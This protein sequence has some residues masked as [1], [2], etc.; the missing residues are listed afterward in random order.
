MEKTKQKMRKGLRRWFRPNGTGRRI[1]TLL[2]SLVMV[3]SL[4]VPMLPAME[5]QAGTATYTDLIPKSTDDATKL[6]AKVVKFNGYDWYIIAD[7]STAV[8]A[9]SVTLLAKECIGASEFDG[10]DSTYSTSTVKSYLDGLTTGSGSFAAVAGAIKSVDLTDPAVSGAKLYLLSYDEAD[11]LPANIRKCNKADGAEYNEWWL[12]SAGEYDDYAACVFGDDGNVHVGGFYVDRARGVRPALQL[13][14]ASVIFSSGSKTFTLK[15]PYSDLVGTTTTVKFNGK[16]WYLIEDNS[17]AGSITLLAKECFSASKFGDTNNSYSAAT[18]KSYLD[19]LT[20][21]SGSFAAVA[22]AIKSVDLSDVGVTGAKLYLLSVSEANA[23]SYS[24]RKCTKATGADINYWW[25]RTAGTFGDGT[26][27][28]ACVAGGENAVDNSGYNG[29][30]TVLGIR[31]ALQ[32]DLSA[33]DFDSETKEFTKAS[34]ATPTFG[35]TAG[36]YA[37]ALLVTIGTETTGATIY[38]TTDGTTPTTSSTKYTKALNITET[39]TVKAIAVKDGLEKSA[40]ASATYTIKPTFYT[41]YLDQVVKFNDMEWYLIGDHSESETSGTVTLLA[42]ECIG[43][44]KFDAAGASNVYAGSTVATYLDTY[45]EENFS[46]FA[47]TIINTTNGRLYLLSADEAEAI[48]NGDIRECSKAS[49]AEANSWWLR[50]VGLNDY[51]AAYVSCGSGSVYLD[52]GHVRNKLGVRPALQLNL[53]KVNFDAEEKTFSP[54]ATEQVKAPE[55]SPV[56][57]SYDSAQSVTISTETTGA[58][59]YYTTDGTAP[60]TSSTKYTGAI[61]VGETTTIKAIAMKA[62][63]ENSAVA[64]ATY[65]IKPTLTGA[66]SDWIPKSTD[67]AAAL[68]DKVVKFSIYNWYI[69]EDDSTAIDAGSV[70]LLAKD[71]LTTS[72]FTNRSDNVYGYSQVKRMLDD[73]ITSGTWGFYNQADAIKSVDLTIYEYGKTTVQETIDGAKLYLLSIEEAKDLPE[74][75]RKCS[76]ITGSAY[77]WWLRSPGNETYYASSVGCDNGEVYD[78][79]GT[80]YDFGVRPAL[81]LDLSKVKFSEETKRFLPLV[82]SPVISPSAGTYS[83]AQ[84]VTISTST[85]G[86]KIYYTTDGTTPSTESTK[87]TGAISISKTTTIK[88]IA[89]ADGMADSDIAS[90]KYTIS[91]AP[92]KLDVSGVTLDKTTL[93]LQEGKTATLT[94]TVTPTDA[95]DKTVTWKSS[96]TTVATVDGSGKVTAEK[97][98]TATITVTATNGTDDTSD[99]QTATCKVTVKEEEVPKTDVSGVTLDNTTLTLQEGK[100]GSLKATVAPTDATDKTVTW[101]SSDT[102]VATVD[103]SGKVTAVKAGTATITVTA[104]NGTDDTSDDKTATCKVTVKEEEVPKVDVSGVTLDNTTLTLQEGKT[105]SLKATV[106]PTDATDKTVTWKSSDTSIATV[107]DSGKVMAVK[108]GTATITVTATNGTDDTSDDQTATCKVTVKE[109]EVPKVDVTGVTLDNTTLTLQ[110]G[111]TGSLKATVAPADATD[112][113]VTWKSS[114]TGVATVDDSGKVTAVKAGTT[115]I[116][117]T[118]TNGTADTADDKTATCTVT[119]SEEPVERVDVIGVTLDQTTLSLTEGESGTLKATVAP[120]DA[121]DATVVWTTGDATVATVDGSGKVTAVKVGTT[122]ITATATN[123]TEDT[124]DDKTATCEV[125]VSEAEAPKVD[126]TGV[127]LDKTTLSIEA[128]KTETLTATVEPEDAADKMVFWSSSDADV[129]TVDADGKITAVKAGTA[130]I[131]VTATNGTEDMEDDKEASCEVTVTDPASEKTGDTLEKQEDGSIRYMKDGSWQSAYTGLVCIDGIWYY[132]ENGVWVSDKY[133]FVEYEGYLFLVANGVLA[134]VNGLQM[135]PNG[136]NWYFCAEG[137]VVKHTGL[138]EYDDEWFYVENGVLDTGLNAL[139]EYD[140]GLFYVAAGRIVR[141]KSG[142]AQDPNSSDWYF[143]ALGE[144]QVKYTG[145]AFYDDEWFYVVNGKLAEDYTGPVEYDGESFNVV[146]GMVK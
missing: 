93:S 120:A 28:A 47:E 77:E 67:N 101:K 9:G 129:V 128:G 79:V 74:N 138:V 33:V 106:A 130:T 86:A 141:D 87:Y 145:L 91:D 109:E 133:G 24:I 75:V 15:T 45:Y 65:T 123:G 7:N 72:K 134:Q 121:T 69:I 89:V 18:V 88:A 85:E 39:T 137:Q 56:A 26:K 29:A 38:Y 57:G 51:E 53:A 70:T 2:M 98:G 125:T 83:S 14:L 105:G 111:K 122:T 132:I 66:Y 118:A 142:L 116:T 3:L 50:S 5:V 61:S 82:A 115:M 30:S 42:K 108:A 59:I 143:L 41:D 76:V 54:I 80:A 4:V 102:G 62:G 46:S 44:S 49:G 112:K 100:T 32:L 126:V 90:A 21:G 55:F 117:V 1:T 73:M 139:V 36:S 31:P 124:A 60:T 136:D 96:D 11:A 107:D 37:G 8:N 17:V 119:V 146:S 104:T 78:D 16:D 99:D 10:T 131:T 58:T 140:G 113:T 103:D 127:T 81:Q 22:G 20:T 114:D 35:L 110:E 27:C 71:P 6:A 63:L 43:A 34:V 25:L 95:T 13:D 68:A 48:T 94:A 52:G 92:P 12:R 135:D 97:A 144:V 64:S 19:G 84:T 23:L 40:V